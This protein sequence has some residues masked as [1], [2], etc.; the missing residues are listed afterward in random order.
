MKIR[1]PLKQQEY[2]DRKRIIAE[3]SKSHEEYE[4]R[5]RLLVEEMGI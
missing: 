2:E 4:R 3:T 1:L 5:I